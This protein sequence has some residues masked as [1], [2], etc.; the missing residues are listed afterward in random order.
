MLP[1]V[2]QQSPFDGPSSY[3]SFEPGVTVAYKPA[4]CVD[5]EALASRGGEFLTHC[6][7]PWIDSFPVTCEGGGGDYLGNRRRTCRGP[8]SSDPV[9]VPA[10]GTANLGSTSDSQSIIFV[11]TTILHAFP[12]AGVPGL[13]GC[14]RGQVHSLPL[15]RPWFVANNE[16]PAGRET[17]FVCLLPSYCLEVGA[18]DAIRR[19]CGC[20]RPF[21][22]LH[23]SARC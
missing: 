1:R 16:C 15:P 2:P 5:A 8:V 17:P 3:R 6:P 21:T 14:V 9:R 4:A 10:T 23:R 18:R 11:T 12:A 19:P 20:L 22:R 7:G 13:R